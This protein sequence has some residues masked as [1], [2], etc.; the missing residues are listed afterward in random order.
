MAGSPSGG[1][2]PRPPPRRSPAPGSARS[3]ERL[4]LSCAAA[5]RCSPAGQRLRG[6]GSAS[7]DPRCCGL[8]TARG[9]VHAGRS[10]FPGG[11][12]LP[13]WRRKNVRSGVIGRVASSDWIPS[14][15]NMHCPSLVLLSHLYWM[16]TQ[17]IYDLLENLYRHRADLELSP[18]KLIPWQIVHGESGSHL[19]RGEPSSQPMRKEQAWALT[20]PV[21]VCL[22]SP[23]MSE[24]RVPPPV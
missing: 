15:S 8:R 10:G 9:G 5:A 22:P 2:E 4:R 23:I 12:A 20:H 6:G 3:R 16:L 17:D 13:G 21:P 18:E 24:E 19:A 1:A 7:P 11:P 14:L